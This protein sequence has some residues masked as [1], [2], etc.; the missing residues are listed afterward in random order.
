MQ[1]FTKLLG[2]AACVSV[3]DLSAAEPQLPEKDQRTGP[4]RTLNTPRTF[5]EIKSKAEWEQRAQ[6]IREQ[7]LVS[8]GLWPLPE[9]TPLNAKIFGRIERDG[10]SVEKVYFQSYPGFYVAGNLY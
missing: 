9:K 7:A 4:V 6:S 1:T 5:P 8:F 2:L 3:I 10:Y